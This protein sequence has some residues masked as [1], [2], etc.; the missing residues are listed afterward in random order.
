MRPALKELDMCFLEGENN[1]FWPTSLSS[2]SIYFLPPIKCVFYGNY[3]LC[4]ARQSRDWRKWLWSDHSPWKRGRKTWR[5]QAG[6]AG[7]KWKNTLWIWMIHLCAC[8][9]KHKDT[10]DA[11]KDRSGCNAVCNNT[12]VGICHC[13]LIPPSCLRWGTQSL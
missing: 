13:T 4:V 6:R 8:K 12:L 7:K 3:V 11:C 2:V 5:R 1:V 9:H 10:N